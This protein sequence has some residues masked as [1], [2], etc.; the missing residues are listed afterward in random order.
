MALTHR[1]N[2]LRNARREGPEWMPFAVSISGATWNQLRGELEDV[3]ERHPTIFPGFQKGQRDFENLEFHPVY[4][5]H[6]RFADNWGCV[7]EC[8]IDGIEGV[9]VEHPLADWDALET[10]RPPDPMT[11]GDRG[12]VDW[13]AQLEGVRKAK[14][15]GGLTQGGLPHGY[16]FMRLYYLRGFEN[17]MLDFATED[18]R[19]QRLIDIL[20]EQ[21]AVIVDQWLTAGVDVMEFA[22]DLGTQTASCIGPKFFA[23]WMTPA[24]S[25]LMQPAKAS[26]ALVALH[27]DGYIM[28]IM[29]ELLVAGVDIINPQDLCNGID[30]LARE[31]KGRACIRLDIDRQSIVP[32]GTRSEIRGL[33]EEEVRKLGSPEGGLE[34]I[35]G[36]Y[37]PTP[38]ENVDALCEALGEFRTYWW[39]G[40]GGV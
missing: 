10:W 16:L 15:A 3:C 12:P 35:A 32:F 33:I 8:A 40:R 29:D 1:E 39:D 27:S 21:N 25:T 4:T 31:V 5:A 17:L 9:V 24:Y 34:M 36:I 37:P 18:P 22:E 6:Q 20:V 7:W 38:A 14:E 30:D 2:Y 23:R 26:H 13:P 28:D 19:L 11:Q